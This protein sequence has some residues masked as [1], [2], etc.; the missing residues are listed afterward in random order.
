[1]GLFFSDFGRFPTA[2]SAAFLFTLFGFFNGLYTQD[3]AAVA[4]TSLSVLL[5][6]LL[7]LLLPPSLLKKWEKGLIFYRE[8]HLNRVAINRNRAAIGEQL[9]ALSNVFRQIEGAFHAMSEQNKSG[10]EDAK[11]YMREEIEEQV[12]ASCPSCEHCRQLGM[13]AQ[14]DK[15]ISVGSAKGK[16]GLIDLPT[17]LSG[18]CVN[19]GGVLFLLNKQ[20]AEYRRYLLE[21]E[22][23]ETGRELLAAQARGISGLLKNIAL[24][25]SEPLTVYTERERQIFNALAKKGIV[26]SEILIYG[27]GEN[28][29]VSLTVFGAQEN[30]KIAQAVSDA[31]GMPLLTGEKLIL[32][33]DKFCYTLRKKPRYDAAFGVAARKKQGA[34]VSGDTHSVT[35][36]DEKRFLAAL[37][38]GMG[39]GKNAER[40]S[41]SAL[42]LLESFYRA[43]MPGETVLSTVNQLLTF[44]REE[45]FACID[46]A[47]VDL[48]SGKADVVK[49]GAPLGFIF[50]AGSIRVLE[51]D[52]LPLGMLEEARPTTMTVQLQ[53]DD[54]LVFLSDGVTDAFG[55]STDL[56]EFLK[57]LEPLNPQALADSIIRAALNRT[58][59]VAKDDMTALAI[60]IFA[61]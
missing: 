15:L 59:G 20:L 22:N 8:S 21:A 38:D 50:S 44:H 33:R 7:F 17:A 10:D 27:E 14:L 45:S 46:L 41:E 23:A 48:E 54:V 42:S 1:M 24:T 47:A 55:S 61:A 52:S 58:D 26:C 6:C 5:P 28:I 13:G 18:E 35:R 49:I 56:L 3:I 51:G 34:T 43:G 19:A 60:R 31:V 29:L 32:S 36:I 39:S 30:A 2:L 16:A 40:I 37:S 25:Q 12:C 4:L 53:D 11:R 57:V 9:F